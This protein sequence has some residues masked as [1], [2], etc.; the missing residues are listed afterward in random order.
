MTSSFGRWLTTPSSRPAAPRRSPSRD[1]N[2]AV[3]AERGRSS[4]AGAI[5]RRSGVAGYCFDER[6]SA[7]PLPHRLRKQDRDGSARRSSRVD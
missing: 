6:P 1:T 4:W 2:G 7:P 5:A 3:G